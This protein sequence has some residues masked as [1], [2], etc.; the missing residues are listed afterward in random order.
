MGL[1]APHAF[2]GER[3]TH[4]ATPRG[5]LRRVAAA[6]GRHVWSRQADLDAIGYDGVPHFSVCNRTAEGP[7]VRSGCERN[8][9]RVGHLP[10]NAVVITLPMVRAR[11]SPLE[12]RIEAMCPGPDWRVTV[13]GPG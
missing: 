5:R 6:S 9:G 4:Q 12:E 1:L 3:R 8:T 10:Q 2:T 7:S 13:D 11:L